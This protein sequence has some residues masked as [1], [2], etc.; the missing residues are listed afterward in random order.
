MREY[1]APLWLPG[2]HA[3]TIYPALLVPR[4]TVAYTR[5]IWTTPDGDNVCVDW[6]GDEQGAAAG[7]P[8]LLL[9]HGLEGSSRSHYALGL[10]RA[11]AERGWRGAVIHWRGCGGLVNRAPRAY[12]SGDSAEADW[13]IR[14]M[15]ERSAGPLYA[16]GVSLGGNVL[17]KWLG[18]RGDEAGRLVAGAG[19]I[20]VPYDLAAGAAM[21]ERGFARLYARSFLRTM[22]PK[23][24]TMLAA[25]PGL[26]DGERLRRAVTLREFDDM[27]T[28]P[29]HGYRDAQD[30]YARA[31]SQA[32]IGGIKVPTLLVSARNDP[33][34]PG[35]FLP[36]ARA[37]PPAVSTL[38]TEQGGH[39]GF[40]SGPLPGRFRWVPAVLFDFLARSSPVH[41]ESA[42]TTGAHHATAAH[43][44]APPSPALRSKSTDHH[45]ATERNL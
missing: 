31:S 35:R 3:Q 5:E 45:A 8:T 15:R 42:H 9:L 30:Y 14:R 43:H 25:H 17:L 38:F 13:M 1:R 23:A 39:A 22:I 41:P 6:C 36:A 27:F 10:M 11:V 40:C 24:L 18:E 33:F 34:L 16:A 7:G 32:Y 20:S 26:F 28:A 21:L 4:A 37:L 2:S 12:H 29:L 44:A 19:A